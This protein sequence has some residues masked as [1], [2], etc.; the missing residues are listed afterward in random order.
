M[1]YTWCL[2]FEISELTFIKIKN[3]EN[4]LMPWLLMAW[5]YTVASRIS[6]KFS[7][8]GN[9]FAQSYTENKKILY[10]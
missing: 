9:L 6:V 10:V 3:R 4:Q 1:K 2:Q 8:A 5:H 7:T